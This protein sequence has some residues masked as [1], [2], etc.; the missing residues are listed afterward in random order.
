MKIE[1]RSAAKDVL[2]V[3]ALIEEQA[4]SK[5]VVDRRQRNLSTRKPMVDQAR[6]WRALVCMRLSS[7]QKSGPGSAISRFRVTQPFP[8]ELATVR[9][10]RKTL[11]EFISQVLF[12]AGL[13]DYN[14]TGAQLEQNFTLLESGGLWEPSLEVCNRL[15]R[16]VDASL[17]R[18]AARFLATKFSGIGPKQSR[19]ILQALGLTRYEIP[20]DSRVIKWL[21]DRLGVRPLGAPLLQDAEFYEFILDAVQRLCADADEF[22]C[23]LDAAIFA[24]FDPDTWTAEEM[25]Y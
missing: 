19:N 5:L 12:D 18:D 2:L 23:M 15:R 13:R 20:L 6:F 11:Q 7:R 10:R 21:R 22:P 14:I 24:S 4:G 3:K 8:L 16:P 1:I 9:G 17:E 25:I